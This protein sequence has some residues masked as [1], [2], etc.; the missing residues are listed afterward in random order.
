MLNK[1]AL[2]TSA[3]LLALGLSFSA[4]AANDLTKPAGKDWPAVAGDW[5]NSRY[6]T[7][8]KI[9]ADNVKKLGGAWMKTFEGAYSRVTPVVVDGTMYVTAGPFVYALNAKTGAVEK[10]MQL[11]QPVLIGPIAMN[12]TIYVVTD[13]AQLIALR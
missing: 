1:T 8:N 5:N 13:E 3:A 6:S 11:G 10:S 2:M 7:L 4:N 12:G 9:N